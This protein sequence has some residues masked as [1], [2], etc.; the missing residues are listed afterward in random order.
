M[1]VIDEWPAACW[2]ASIGAPASAS[3]VTNV[4]RPPWRVMYGSS[5]FSHA[6]RARVASASSR[7]GSDSESPNARPV[8]LG[9]VGSAR[10]RLR[11][12]RASLATVAPPAALGPRVLE[13]R[14]QVTVDRIVEIAVTIAIPA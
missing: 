6:F 4:C 3:K 5:A 10:L 13:P 8:S 12:F 11:L 14:R 1:T 2:I 7:N 9:A